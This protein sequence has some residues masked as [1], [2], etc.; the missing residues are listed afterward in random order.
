ME[1]EIVTTKKKLT[2]SIVNQMLELKFKELDNATV[3]GF[4][5]NVSP[6]KGK[7]L[8]LEIDR[9]E[10]RIAYC[11]W[12]FWETTS[13]TRPY[14]NR[15]TTEWTFDNKEDCKKYFDAI[16]AFKEEAIQIYI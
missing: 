16:Q 2:K 10:Y 13:L 12:K 6:T 14:K 5:I 9:F 3:L 8:I 7:V 1:I 11:N 15:Y 4:V